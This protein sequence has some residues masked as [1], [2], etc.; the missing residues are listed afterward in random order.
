MTSAAEPKNA[1]TVILVRPAQS[2]GGIEVFL[3]RRPEGM[4]FLGGAYVFPGGTIRKGDCAAEVLKRCGGVALQRAKNILGAHLRP[5]AALGHWVAGIREL[6]EEV[7]VLLCV[8][9]DGRPLEIRDGKRAQLEEKRRQIVRRELSFHEL[10]EAERLY[11]DAGGLLYFSHWLTPEEFAI[12]FDT[13]FFVAV[14]PPG[15]SPLEKS[16]EVAHGLWITPERAMQLYARGSLPMILPT[17]AS[18][19]TLADFDSV[20]SLMTDYRRN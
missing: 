11:C 12:R 17:Y 18:L 6:F 16:E 5:E 4:D 1:A 2:G 9:E 14:L 3:T 8:G 20:E 10:L 19:R 15:Q 13:R 7:G